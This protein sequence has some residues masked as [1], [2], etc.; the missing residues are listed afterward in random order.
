MME[1]LG[2]GF[3]PNLKVLTIVIPTTPD[4]AAQCKGDECVRVVVMTAIA[5]ANDL[6]HAKKM[7]ASIA[8]H[9]VI[10]VFTVFQLLTWYPMRMRPCMH[11]N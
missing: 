11:L 10:M 7:L 4:L 1:E 2:P 6:P 8:D 3:D 9:K 5:F